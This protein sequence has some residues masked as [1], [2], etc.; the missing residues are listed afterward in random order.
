MEETSRI[1][2]EAKPDYI[3]DSEPSDEEDVLSEG[4]LEPVERKQR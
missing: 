1:E 3:P 2:Q 4:E